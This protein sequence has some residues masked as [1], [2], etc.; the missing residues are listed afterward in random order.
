MKTR[1]GFIKTN[2]V[3]RF[4]FVLI[5]VYSFRNFLGRLHRFNVADIRDNQRKFFQKPR[6][7]KGL[8]PVSARGLE[9]DVDKKRNVVG[10]PARREFDLRRLRGDDQ[11]GFVRRENPHFR[12][13]IARAA[14]MIDNREFDKRNREFFD[15][16]VLKNAHQ[17]DFVAHLDPNVVAQE[18]VNQL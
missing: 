9:D 11:I 18:S 8:H 12:L 1:D 3:P 15:H 4:F 14:P 13:M 17:R 16:Y 7:R 5:L 6:V 2:A 10:K